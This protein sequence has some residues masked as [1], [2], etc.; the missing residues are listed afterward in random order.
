MELRPRIV[1]VS[2]LIAIIEAA[3]TTLTD[4]L[5]K[6]GVETDT[7]NGAHA[8]FC[9]I[10]RGLELRRSIDDTWDLNDINC[11]AIPAICNSFLNVP[12]L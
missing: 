4:R 12:P 10:A 11:S 7:G 1:A 6:E 9:L 3:L 5:L 2:E 8:F